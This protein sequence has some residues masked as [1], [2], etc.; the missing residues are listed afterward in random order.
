MRELNG[1]FA[2][3]AGLSA[4]TALAH[5]VLGGPELVPVLEAS[6]LSAYEVTL[7]LMLFHITTILLAI[8]SAF[9]TAAAWGQGRSA[10]G[11]VGVGG[12]GAG[13]AGVGGAGV[14]GVGHAPARAA[15]AGGARV[16][17]VPGEYALAGAFDAGAGAG[18]GAGRGAG[19][20][21]AGR[22]A[23]GGGSG[24]IWL[25]GLTYGAIGAVFFWQ[26]LVRLGNVWEMPQW[27]V[28]GLICALL[29]RG[30]RRSRA[31]NGSPAGDGA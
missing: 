7:S 10:A 8:N 17:E 4:L 21:G 30:A 16:G 22:G 6:G 2:G 11:G 27:L 1:W 25:I 3:A 9:L 15:P 19:G 5:V 23:A 28:L 26:G 29:W 20:G 14:G 31:G 13:G 18:G 12:A 24:T